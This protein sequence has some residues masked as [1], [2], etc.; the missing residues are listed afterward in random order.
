MHNLFLVYFVNLYMFRTYFCPSS[1]C[2]LRL[3]CDGTR[4]ETKFRLSTSPFKSAE[5]SVQS[6]T[7]SRGVRIRGS[8][9]RYTMFRGSV[10]NTGYPLHPSVSPSV[11]LPCVT[12]CHHISTGLCNR[13]YT[14]DTYYFFRLLFSWLDNR[15]SSKNKQ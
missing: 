9:A 10:K 11:P 6:T 15:Q 12:L 3:K 8:N 7:D 1:G 5:A 2:R 4:A 13:M 14:T